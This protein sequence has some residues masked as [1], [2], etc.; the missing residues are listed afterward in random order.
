VVRKKA[1]NGFSTQISMITYENR[2]AAH[3]PACTRLKRSRILLG[4]SYWGRGGAEVA[5]MWVLQALCNAY[6]VDIVTRGGWCLD[7]L[8]RCSGT[9]VTQEW[10]GAVR[11]PPLTPQVNTTG[12]ALWH[13]MFLRHCRRLAP[14]YD[15]CITASRTLDWGRPAIHFLS[16]VAWNE[17]LQNRFQTA[18][19]T[20][21]EGPVRR[22][23]WKLGRV[24]AGSS[25]RE[26]AQHD[27]FVANSQWTARMSSE[28]CKA[29][30][31]VIYPAV[32][33]AERAMPWEARE[34]SFI[35]LGRIS[36]E[37]RIQDVI[38][39]LDR[40]RAAGHPVRLHLVGAGDDA[41]Y[42]QQVEQLCDARREWMV[43]HGP[44]YGA[45]K[46]AILNRCRF[47]I[48]ACEREA[49]GIATAEMIKAGVVPFVPS[50]GAQSE[51]VQEGEL[52]YEDIQDAAL[53]I[54]AV[55]RSQTRQQE[56]HGAMLR[57]GAE[58]TPD[59]FCTEVRNLVERT[60][61][62]KAAFG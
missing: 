1:P 4:H 54:D 17:P 3:S 12:G 5:A 34:D 2:D 37:K 44:L 23:Y 21:E 62:E 49:F 35:C 26:P 36:P 56:L 51:I 30:P 39:I 57:Q 18:E 8:N 27:I 9:N 46:Q 50:E 43:F 29:P 6:H 60:L 20:R 61:S 7:D 55:L 38:A 41:G 40:V 58:F 19:M 45:E 16:D 59:R 48:S 25:G 14:Q 10:L 13:A 47:G 33:G 53:K 32:P 42:V 31:V 24:L 28:Y 22:F 11:H 52:I 15:L